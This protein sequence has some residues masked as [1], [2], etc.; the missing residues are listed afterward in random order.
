MA[1]TLQ[2]PSLDPATALSNLQRLGESFSAATIS[3]AKEVLDILQ[4]IKAPPPFVFPTDI[5]GVQFEWHGGRR[6]LNIEISPVESDLFYV[7]FENGTPVQEAAAPI[8]ES[9]LRTL[10]RWLA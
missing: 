7:T 6:E 5:A 2:K 1:A 4:R 9:V 3:R 8:E 10:V